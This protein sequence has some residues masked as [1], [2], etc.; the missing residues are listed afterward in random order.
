MAKCMLSF[1]LEY[2]GINVQTERRAHSMPSLTFPFVLQGKFRKRQK[3]CRCWRPPP[4]YPLWFQAEDCCQFPPRLHFRTWVIE[5]V[6]GTSSHTGARLHSSLLSVWFP[7]T[8]EPAFGESDHGESRPHSVCA[9]SASPHRECRPL[10]NRWD[11]E[12]GV[13]RKLKLAGKVE[14]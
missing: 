8:A 4:R 9:L 12:D 10:E 6:L 11:Q 5:S 2:S 1:S 3:L 14:L 13:R 7:R